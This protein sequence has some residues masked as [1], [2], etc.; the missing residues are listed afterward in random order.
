MVVNYDGEDFPG[1]ITCC[2]GNDQFEVS[3]MHKSGNHWKWPKTID[4]IL[5]ARDD[6]CEPSILP[7]QQDTVDSVCSSTVAQ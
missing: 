3:V 2:D 1:E 6:M 4:K 5:Y 7:E